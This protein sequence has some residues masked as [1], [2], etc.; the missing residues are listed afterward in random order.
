MKDV[1]AVLRQ[2]EIEQSRLEKEVEALRVV[3]PL[4][5]EDGEAENDHQPTLP[6]AVNDSP[7][8]T[9]VDGKTK[10]K[11]AGRK[12]LILVHESH[13][14]YASSDSAVETTCGK[15]AVAINRPEAATGAAKQP[16]QPQKASERRASP[17]EEPVTKA[18][19]T[20]RSL[21]HFRVQGLGTDATG[22]VGRCC[23]VEERAIPSRA[24]EQFGKREP[25]RVPCA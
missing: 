11:S 3:A 5:S 2:K 19:M 17:G 14:C 7:S 21:G 4:L 24:P 10:P 15:P 23:E 25:T 9:T 12:H 1:Y 6:R 22:L 18:P 20:Y 16:P 13:N 8:P